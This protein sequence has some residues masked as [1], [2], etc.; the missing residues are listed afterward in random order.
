MASAKRP[1]VVPDARSGVIWLIDGAY[2][3]KGAQGK[4]DYLQLRRTLQVWASENQRFDRCIFF[5]SCILDDEAQTRFHA[6]MENN[7]FELRL[8]DI[9]KMKATCPT[10]NTCFHRQVQKGVDVGLCT[11]LLELADDYRRVV[12]TAGDGDFI[13]AIRVVK[14]KFKEVYISGFRS[15]MSSEFRQEATKM[16]WIEDVPDGASSLLAFQSKNKM[17]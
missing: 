17:Y 1:R 10:C 16:H 2:V 4:I 9:K 14:R 15:S 8:Y 7:G 5:N 11:V 12:L 3:L 6:W 13:D